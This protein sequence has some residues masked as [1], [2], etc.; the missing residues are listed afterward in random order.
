MMSLLM[1]MMVVMQ[2]AQRQQDSVAKDA[3]LAC[4]RA[5]PS[6]TQP[7]LLSGLGLGSMQSIEHDISHLEASAQLSSLASCAVLRSHWAS[8]P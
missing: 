1:A 7:G 6:S 3:E 5:V 8:P 4:L 2:V